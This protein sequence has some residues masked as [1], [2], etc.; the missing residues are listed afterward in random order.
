MKNFLHCNFYL[1][2]VVI[3]VGLFACNS[4]PVFAQQEVIGN[5]FSIASEPEWDNEL[6]SFHATSYPTSITCSWSGNFAGSFQQFELQRGEKSSEFVTVATIDKNKYCKAKNT[7]CYDDKNVKEQTKYFYR[8]KFESMD[9][10]TTYSTIISAKVNSPSIVIAEAS[11]NPY[12]ERTTIQYLLSS[13]S[14][15]TLEISNESG[16]VVKRYQQG[17]QKEGRYAV[18]FSAKEEGLPAGKYYVNVWFDDDNY[19]LSIT[20]TE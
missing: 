2:R 16:A 18:P 10:M 1:I 13:P 20:E 8:L 15:V 6:L 11:P 14:M 3:F 4:K 12:K 17:L 7:F 19:Q 5:V 9:G